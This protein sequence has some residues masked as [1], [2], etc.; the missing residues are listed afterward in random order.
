MKNKEDKHDIIVRQKAKK[1]P[2]YKAPA[3]L[4]DKPQKIVIVNNHGLQIAMYVKPKKVKRFKAGPELAHSRSKQH[5]NDLF[6]IVNVELTIAAKKV[7]KFK[8]GAE[9]AQTVKR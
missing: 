1:A 9:L 3:E 6:E 5:W 2:K 7:K 8:P 4:S